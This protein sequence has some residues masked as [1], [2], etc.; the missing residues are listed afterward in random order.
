MKIKVSIPC[1]IVFGLLLLSGFQRGQQVILTNA[2]QVSYLYYG[3]GC[4]GTSTNTCATTG[5]TLA[6]SNAFQY[7]SPIATG[8]DALGYTVHACGLYNGQTTGAQTTTMLCA[9]YDSGATT[10]P[11]SGCTVTT[12]SA[13]MLYTSWTE[14]TNFSGCTLAASTTYYMEYQVSTTNTSRVYNTGATTD[15]HVATYGTW[16]SSLTWSTLANELFNSYI[17]VTA[18]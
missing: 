11:V 2:K 5:T 15:Y 9:I 6:T 14:N 12:N 7:G 4:A 10:S 17:R 3:A 16:G 8:S 13:A 18:N 1:L